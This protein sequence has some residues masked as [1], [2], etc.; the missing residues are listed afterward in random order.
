MELRGA[1]TLLALT[2]ALAACGA[3]DRAAG[4]PGDAALDVVASF[5]P[6]A[7]AAA[8]VG[9]DQVRVT[10][11]TPAGTE[12]HDL[13]LTPS[14]IDQLEDADLVV[15]LG[16]GFQPGVQ[17]VA[18]RRSGPT[19]DLLE[20]AG[21]GPA[22]GGGTVDPHFW[23]DPTLLS[24]AAAAIEAELAALAPVGAAVHSAAERYR[25]ELAALDGRLEAGLAGCRRKDIV[26]SHAAFAYLA[27]R[28]G[29][30]QRPVAG[31]SPESEPD[32]RRLDEL[33]DLIARTG[34]T[35]VFSE[36]LASPRV[37]R[38]LAREEG[39]ATAVLDPI[40]GLTAADLEAGADYAAVMDR[41]LA[42]LRAA[43]DCP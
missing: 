24:R 16:R 1:S 13:E 43:L 22:A 28:Y 8:R 31:L 6:V 3:G 33:A 7:E 9:G 37:A 25:Q 34:T 30:I 15:Y 32:A 40:E 4:Q 5:Y 38:A 12:P 18:E 2:V 27:R 35:T 20:G 14:Q 10:N 19:L 26:T 21:V 41:N 17:A 23:L 36:T 11:L 29:L 39:V 42:I